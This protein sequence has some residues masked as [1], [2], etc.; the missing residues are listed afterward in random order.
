MSSAFCIKQCFYHVFSCKFHYRYM[1]T[2]SGDLNGKIQ[3]SIIQSFDAKNASV[4]TVLST[5][6][7]APQNYRLPLILLHFVTI[8]HILLHFATFCY[9]L[10]HFATFCYILLHFATFCYNLLHFA[11]FCYILLHF[12]TFATFCYILLHF[13]TFCYILYIF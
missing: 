11:T 4:A 13:A 1:L 8:C 5:C 10:L 6:A 7:I 12:A 2:K 3:H 9:I